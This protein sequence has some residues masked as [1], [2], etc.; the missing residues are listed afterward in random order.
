MK[1]Q[2]ITLRGQA[3]TLTDAAERELRSYLKELG[4]ATVIQKSAYL[5]CTE[6]LRDVLEHKAPKGKTVTEKM[7]KQAIGIV[8][9]PPITTENVFT[10]AKLAVHDMRVRLLQFEDGWRGAWRLVGAIIAFLALFAGIF[11]GAASILM[12]V[13]DHLARRGTYQE[14]SYGVVRM[15]QLGATTRLSTMIVIACLLF[16]A[17][18][19]LVLCSS[20]LLREKHGWKPWVGVVVGGLLFGVAYLH[21]T[22]TANTVSY[23]QQNRGY[24]QACSREVP[25]YL[26]ESAPF[27]LYSQLH[28]EGYR[29]AAKIPTNH[30]NMLMDFTTLCKAYDKLSTTPGRDPVLQLYKTAANGSAQ[31][32][33][34][35]EDTSS[36]W[37]FGLFAKQ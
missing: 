28:K 2:K 13:F 31:P 11:I 33:D 5:E 1:T 12:V 10:S 29:L 14:F 24:L 30:G 3:F 32:F 6:A 35:F 18:G 34:Q 9:V 36:S 25:I 7:M 8:G 17:G 15:N 27:P 23:L 22:S 19:L 16:I 26:P 4:R 37:S 20:W 21:S